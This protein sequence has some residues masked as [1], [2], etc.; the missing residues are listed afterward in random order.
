MKNHNVVNDDTVLW[1][2]TGLVLAAA[3]IL[4][5]QGFP[6]RWHA[7]IMWTAVAFGPAIV[8]RRKRWGSWS[9]WFVCTGYLS[10]HLGL[11]WLLFAYLLARV[12][13]LGT[14]YVVPFASIEAFVLLALLSNRRVAQ[15]PGKKSENHY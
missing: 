5:R 12:S 1:I 10:L 11:M 6:Q 13:V 2:G 4:D 15:V 3:I 7:A 8:V 9:F 14:L